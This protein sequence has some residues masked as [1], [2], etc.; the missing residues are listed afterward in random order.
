MDKGRRFGLMGTLL[1]LSL[2]HTLT[3]TLSVLLL[4]F[5]F[6]SFLPSFRPPFFPSLFDH[7]HVSSSLFLL[8]IIAGCEHGFCLSCIRAW[9]STSRD[10]TNPSTMV[11]AC[12]TCRQE[13][14]FVFPSSGM[15]FVTITVGLLMKCF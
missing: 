11:K 13:S 15:V 2:S 10:M 4:V 1:S 8:V 7:M 9:R 6:I 14:L 3:H 12:P 5:L